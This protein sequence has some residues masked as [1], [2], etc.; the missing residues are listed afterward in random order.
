MDRVA[1][2]GS[3]MTPFGEREAWIQE[4]LAEAG[5]ACLEGAGVSPDAVDHCYVSNMASGEFEGQ[6]GTMNALVGDLG[7]APAYAARIDQTSASG[8]AGIHARPNLVKNSVPF[9]IT[10]RT[11]RRKQSRN[12][13]LRRRSNCVIF[14]WDHRS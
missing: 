10:P 14:R 5:S 7:L 2:L 13:L 3:A 12:S 11:S 4:L 6:G 8:G 1:I 9:W